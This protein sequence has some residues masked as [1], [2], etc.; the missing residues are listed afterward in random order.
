[1][2]NLELGLTIDHADSGTSDISMIPTK[3]K[4]KHLLQR[5]PENHSTYY[6]SWG[7]L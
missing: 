6:I 5:V 7:Y 4:S 1:M 2:S 3:R